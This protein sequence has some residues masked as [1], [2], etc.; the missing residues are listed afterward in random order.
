ELC[1]AF[2]SLV[3]VVVHAVHTEARKTRGL[4]DRKERGR[5]ARSAQILRRRRAC[6]FRMTE[7][8]NVSRQSPN[9]RRRKGTVEGPGRVQARDRREV[10]TAIL[11]HKSGWEGCSSVSLRGVGAD[12][13]EAGGALHFQSYEEEVFG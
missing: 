2:T 8:E 6:R 5:F 1:A 4:F 10:R 12:R 3:A 7:Q 11:H 9:S 13:A